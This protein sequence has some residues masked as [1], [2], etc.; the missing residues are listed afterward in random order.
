MTNNMM[1][2]ILLMVQDQEKHMENFHAEDQLKKQ[3]TKKL[4]S[5]KIWPVINA[6][7][8]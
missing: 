7:F 2:C 6:L 4:S 1:F 5:L 3:N 8:K